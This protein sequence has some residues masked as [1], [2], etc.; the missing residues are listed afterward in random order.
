MSVLC[1]ARILDP[2]VA[3]RALWIC[4]GQGL[5]RRESLTRAGGGAGRAER[6]YSRL[7]KELHDMSDPRAFDDLLRELRGRDDA[8]GPQS[9][10]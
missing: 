1:L 6:R 9:P 2:L 3:P 10:A 7:P 4:G 5:R 8:A